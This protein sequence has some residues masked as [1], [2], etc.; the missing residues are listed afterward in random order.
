MQIVFLGTACM[1]PTKERNHSAVLITYKSEGILV[2]CG[3]GT[4][5]QMKLAGI[6]PTKVTKILL[7]H[8][9]GDHVL[10]LPGLLQTLGASEYTGKLEIYGPAGTKKHMKAMFEAFVFDRPFEIRV[11]E[12]EGGKFIDTKEFT[13]EALP[14]QHGIKTLGFAFTER[15]R[16]KVDMKKAAKLGLKEGPAIGSLQEGNPVVLNGKKISPDDVTYVEKGRKVSI[17][18]DTLLCDNCYRLAKDADILISEAC[19]TSSLEEK[20]KEYKHMTAKWAGIVAS[21]S[22]AKKLIIT[23]FSAR[24]KN[25]LELQ[26]DAQDVFDNVQCAEDL[27]KVNL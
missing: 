17:I 26:K 12:V 22:N 23:H 18:S 25:A 2:D 9:H 24:Y 16:R 21:Q 6:K 14:L 27:M 4:Q 3:E 5:R 7:S 8:W 20:A 19:Y 11:E 1:V 13:I 15:D 10:G